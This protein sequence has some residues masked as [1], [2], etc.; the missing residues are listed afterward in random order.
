MNANVNKKLLRISGILAVIFVVCTLVL[1]IFEWVVSGISGTIEFL[2][3]GKR[4]SASGDRFAVITLYTEDT[5][6]ISKDQAESWVY[7]METALLNSSIA[8]K[9]NARS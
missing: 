3:A 8:P 6:A 7:R 1:G 5:A 9:E 2:D 4:W